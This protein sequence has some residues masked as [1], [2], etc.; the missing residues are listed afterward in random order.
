MQE[1]ITRQIFPILLSLSLSGALIGIFIAAIHPFTEKYF[2]KKWNYYIWLLVVI[3][4]LLPFHFEFDFLKPLNFHVGFSQYNDKAQTGGMVQYDGGKRLN[5][6]EQFDDIQQSKPNLPRSNITTAQHNEHSTALTQ[7]EA[8]AA[9]LGAKF[10]AAG[11]WTAAAYIWFLGAIFAFFIKLWNYWRFKNAIKKSCTRITDNRIVTMENAFCSKLHIEKIPAIYESTAVSGPMTIGLWNPMIVIPKIF[12]EQNAPA[13]LSMEQ[14]LTHFQLVLHH[15]LIHV[16]RKDLLYKW[17][18]QILLCVH[19]F[20]PVLHSVTRQI[21][22]DCELSCD[23]AILPEL[24]ETGKQMYGNI[25][26]DTAEQT[27]ARRQNVFSTTLLENKENLKKRLDGILRYKKATRL[28]LIVSACAL[29]IMLTISACSTVWI[30]ADDLPASE[31][32]HSASD[33]AK[34]ASFDESGPLTTALTSLISPDGFM[35]NFSKPSRSS[36]AWK[37]YDDDELLAGDDIQ[38][39]WGAYNYSGGNHKISASGFVLY[40]SD[41]FLIAYAEKEVDVK[42]QTSYDLAEGNFKIVY[43]APDKSILTLNDTG[44]E[45]TQTITMQKGRNVLKMVGQGAKLKNLKI[46]YTNLKISNFKEIYYSEEEEYVIQVK[47]A[48]IAGEPIEKD[49]IINALY[50]MDAKDASEVFNALLTV[51]TKFT[52]DEFC[53]FFLYSDQTLSSR[54][55][56]DAIKSGSIEPLSTDAISQLMPYLTGDCPTELLKSLPVEEFYDVFADNIVYLND[57]QITEC[58]TD[59]LNRGGVL[60]FSMYDEISPYVSKNTTEKLDRILP[61]LPNIP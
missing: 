47:D 38:D 13:V 14:N 21:N 61:V 11:I 19:W 4:L 17:V 23:E 32:R 18:C 36:D 35:D 31:S 5:S 10:S 60:T 9:L 39:N 43:I 50:C 48:L 58:L 28:R 57:D 56:S 8:D 15:E 16:A 42:I 46:D 26:L 7:P 40:G 33:D 55:L 2:S 1:F 44:A 27:I 53:D 3:R 6:S 24:T 12:S 45:T 34:T 25:L 37:V 20:N 54:Y 59:Y 41:T 49:K 29:I 30:S 52:D 22:R 51:G